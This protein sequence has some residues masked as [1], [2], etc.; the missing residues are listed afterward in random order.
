M[1]IMSGV[2]DG[3][4]T[5]CNVTL[6]MFL[7]EREFEYL[8]KQIKLENLDG[9]RPILRKV[10]EETSYTAY[11]FS[12]PIG[13]SIDDFIDN[14][15]ALSQYL[16][17]KEGDV[18]IELVNNQALITVKDDNK[19]VSF[20]YKDYEFEN[21]MKVPIGINLL[22]HKIV[23]WEF[24]NAP[25]LLIAGSSGGGKSVMLGVI[26]S[27][28][29]KHI[30][31]AELYMQDTKY[32]DLF[33]FKDCKQTKYYGENKEG[34]EETLD[35]LMSVMSERYDLIRKKHL[36]DV[37]SY[38]E[39]FKDNKINPIFLIIEEIS[40][41]DK[42]DK[43][44]KNFYNKLTKL[45]NKGRG[46]LIEVILTTQTPYVNCVPGD[47]KN[48]LGTT[49]G[50]RCNTTQA[51]FSVCGDADILTKLKGKGHARLFT[52]GNKIEFQGFN[53]KDETIER[54]VKEVN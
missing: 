22:T 54:I 28:I 32:L 31:T 19:D 41:F 35:Y 34:I 16:H 9:H 52:M 27:Y 1:K 8:F 53:I 18:N 47:I 48:C 21:E 7:G 6:D 40:S 30:P 49:I 2:I 26:V 43:N 5:I 33:L 23:Y 45:I 39:K 42:E 12:I 36:R 44:D 51:S 25:H 20:N 46:C 3:L 14:K 11:L 10:I 38:N 24:L 37:S 50:L 13:L 29:I 4:S 15:S 17:K